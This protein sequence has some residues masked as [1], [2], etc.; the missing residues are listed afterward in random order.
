MCSSCRKKWAAVGEG[1]TLLLKRTMQAKSSKIRKKELRPYPLR[2]E[3]EC[4]DNLELEFPRI[5]PVEKDF[6]SKCRISRNL[7]L[8]LCM[9]VFLSKAG[10]TSWR[11]L[12]RSLSHNLLTDVHVCYCIFPHPWSPIPSPGQKAM[13]LSQRKHIFCMGRTTDV[14]HERERLVFVKL[15]RWAADVPASSRLSL[16]GG[17][18][19]LASSGRHSF[20]SLPK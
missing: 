12:V 18:Q 6:C 17:L 2:Y 20:P 3:E 5:A 9:T 1:T 19:D 16:Y 8:E 13:L 4:H 15:C 10:E 14:Q 11:S 7:A